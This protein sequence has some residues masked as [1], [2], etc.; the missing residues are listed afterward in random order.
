MSRRDMPCAWCGHK[1]RQHETPVPKFCLERLMPNGD[2]CE[3]PGYT[4]PE[5]RPTY[6]TED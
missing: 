6:K 4:E 5:S 2:L 1:L 3:C